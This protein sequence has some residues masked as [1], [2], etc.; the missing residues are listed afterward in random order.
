MLGIRMEFTLDEFFAAGGVVTF[1]DRMAAVLGIHAADIKVVSVTAGSTIVDFFVQ[2]AENVE[3]ILD[4]ESIEETFTEVVETMEEFMGSPVLN[5]VAN[6]V[7]ILTPHGAETGDHGGAIVD[8]QFPWD[9]LIND[10]ED[11]EPK[12]K[13]I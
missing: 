1:A 13:Q 7:P 4:L 5:A 12:E 6:G 11:E 10:D 9:D 3:E 2:Q 8:I